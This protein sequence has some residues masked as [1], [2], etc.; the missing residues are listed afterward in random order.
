M[1]CWRS[2]FEGLLQ[3][4]HCTKFFI[5]VVEDPILM[6]Y[7]NIWNYLIEKIIVVEDPILRGYYNWEEVDTTGLT[8]VEAPI[9]R[10]YY[11]CFVLIFKDSSG[12]WRPHFEGLLQPLLYSKNLLF[13]CW[14][15]HFEGL[16]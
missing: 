12:C 7:Y 8:V 15:P 14:R 10:G 9:L 1:C 5:Q 16:L 11:N 3:Q 4:A 2:H 13:C 6:G